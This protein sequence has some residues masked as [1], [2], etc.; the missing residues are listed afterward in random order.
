MDLTRFEREAVLALEH[1]DKV[2]LGR[3]HAIRHV[4]SLLHFG[5]TRKR[6]ARTFPSRP[7]VMCALVCRNGDAIMLV[8]KRR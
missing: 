2:R 3:S 6:I 1:I 5:S 4:F 7:A 8:W